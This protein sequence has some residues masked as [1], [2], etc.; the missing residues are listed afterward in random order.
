[1]LEKGRILPFVLSAMLITSGCSASTLPER[2]GVSKVATQTNN[3]SQGK[4]SYPEI[5]KYPMQASGEFA[6][7][8]GKVK[9]MNFTDFAFNPGAAEQL[10]RF[11]QEWALQSPTSQIPGIKR[12]LTANLTRRP[13]RSIDLYLI[14]EKAPVPSWWVANKDAGTRVYYFSQGYEEAIT[15]VRV[16]KPVTS[17]DSDEISNVRNK[18]AES[19]LAIETCQA[20]MRLEAVGVDYRVLQEIFCNSAGQAS[21]MRK[22]NYP[23]ES[24]ARLSSLIPMFDLAGRPLPFVTFP[25]SRYAA[26]S[27]ERIISAK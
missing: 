3:L 5:A 14:P 16:F 23:Y 8:T 10:F 9:W 19:F 17:F 26:F 13:N 18:D 4:N 21:F 27:S 20:S 22:N 24:Y 12:P 15:I 11:Y 1:M 25:S 7:Q 6:T 2:P